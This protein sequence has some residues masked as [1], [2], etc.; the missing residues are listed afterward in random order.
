M[1]VSNLLPVAA[2]LP[3]AFG[4]LHQLAV[5]KGL[6]Y[7]G[8]A[9]DNPNNDNQYNGIIS[10]SNNFGQITPANQMKWDTVEPSQGNFQYSKG[11]SIVSFAKSHNQIMRCHTTV[12]YNQL[13]NWVSSINNNGTL[14]NAL[15]N[16]VT[17]EV[18]HWKGQCYAWD[19][20]NEAFEDSG[21]FRN[22]V[23]YRL[24]GT[25]FIPIAFMAAAAADPS[26][27]LYYNDYNIETSGA[28]ATQ[29]YNVV[30]AMKNRGIKVDGV[31]L[32]AHF[33]VGQT[34]RAAQ[35][36]IL[37]YYAALGVEVAYTELDIRFQQLPPSS[38]QL[39]QQA[40]DYVGVVGAC[41]DVAAC[42]GITVWDFADKYSWIP[43]VFSGNGQACFW[44]DNYSTKPAYTSVIA[45]LSSATS[46]PH[47]VGVSTAPP[48]S[49]SIRPTSTSVPTTI[50]TV[51]S[52]VTSVTSPTD[53]TTP[54]VDTS[55]TPV[56]T[57]P[58][59]PADTPTPT[60]TTPP[61]TPPPTTG[62]IAKWAQC[63]GQGWSGSGS[64]VSGTSCQTLNPYYSQ[65]L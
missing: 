22:S 30:K 59:T 15:K 36:S 52:P 65:C 35:V 17:Q 50:Q 48:S 34:T 47:G 27:K 5:A 46:K 11:D 10:N 53:V 16:H 45:L 56:T 23:F 31:G 42:V 55:T 18:N 49:T 9:T 57:P 25:E 19:V 33:V 14:I 44:S 7:F 6:K 41:L 4:Q 1:L 58:T 40:T 54:P 24:I 21:P 32:Q 8:T 12:W 39:Q 62:N 20:V 29:T 13:P 26:A 60:S 3:S 37:N 38:Q 2:L 61:Y 64:C 51:T 63:G 43:G 28:K